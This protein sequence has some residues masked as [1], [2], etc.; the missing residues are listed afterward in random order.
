MK[1][2]RSS[3]QPH[4]SL[5]GQAFRFLIGGGVNTLLSYVVYWVLLTQLPYAAA[6]TISYA[7]CLLTGFAI[8][9][10]FVFRTHWSWRKLLSFPMIQVA[11]Y[12]AGLC[13][14]WISVSV[15]GVDKRIAP[16]I[17]T[18]V[19]LPLNFALTRMLMHSRATTPN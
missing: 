4:Q 2:E 16:V 17:A 1:P 7:I 3:P 8:N 18:V 6:Y 9:T 11:N 10:R 12:L 19:V 14:M 5:G 13:V 15:L